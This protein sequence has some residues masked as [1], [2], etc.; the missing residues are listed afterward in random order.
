[1]N[2][3]SK[4]EYTSPTISSYNVDNE[5][6]MVMSSEV[7]TFPSELNSIPGWPESGWSQKLFKIIFR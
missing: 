5:I 6:S 4:K 1:M 7:P 3:K 2:F